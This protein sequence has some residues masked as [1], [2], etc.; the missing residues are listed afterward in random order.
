MR[1]WLGEWGQAVRVEAR[2]EADLAVWGPQ[3]LSAAPATPDAARAW[4]NGLTR[5]RDGGSGENFPV[6]SRLLPAALRDDFAAVY[7]FCR[8]A[9]DLADHSPS[10]DRA[11][12]RLAWWRQQLHRGF[13]GDPHHPVFVALAP[14]VARHGLEREP[15]DDL[16]DAF[17]QDQ[18]VS[19]YADLPQLLHYCQR[20]ANSVG[21]IVLRLYGA[22]DPPR[23][24][25]ADATCTALQLTNFWQDVRRDALER[26]RVYLPADVASRHGLD[27]ELMLRQLKLEAAVACGV[28]C[29]PARVGQ[30]VG[31]D[32]LPAFRAVVGELVADTRG[33]F[34]AGRGLWPR[35]PARLRGGL[36]AFTLGGEAVLRTIERRSFD[37]YT[38]RPRVGRL[39]KAWVLLRAAAGVGGG[40]RG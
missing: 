14:V 32:F 3:A 34:E 18:R 27:L 1:A 11:L 23:A 40:L 8:W 24:E 4:V 16:I 2:L 39:G 26:G 5:S 15:F 17:E 20:S 38:R 13:D 19:R 28:G 12:E 22:Y 36:R 25:L 33:R 10:P 9:D 21:R 30:A 29:P 7:A 6:L 37:T 35:V 31:P